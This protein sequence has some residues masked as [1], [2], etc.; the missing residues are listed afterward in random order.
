MMDEK[1]P[2]PAGDNGEPK[3]PKN[4]ETTTTEDKGT[5]PYARFAEVITQKQTAEENLK[6]L[7]DELVN[8]LP[9]EFRPL[10]P[11]LP[12]A[13]KAAWI[14]TARAAGLFSKSQGQPAPELDTKRPAGKTPADLSQLNPSQLLSMGYK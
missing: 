13:A 8:D 5:V 10:V 3:E 6:S 14:R 4:T 1:K 2:A 7:V 12:P 11:A 9:E